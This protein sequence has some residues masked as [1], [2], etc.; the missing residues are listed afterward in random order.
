MSINERP[1]ILDEKTRIGD[2]EIDTVIGKNH[3]LAIV[4]IV[5]RKSK[6][7]LL[8]K[9]SHKQLLRLHKQL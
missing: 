5:E 6:V 4:S 1:S 3:K 9:V 8:A 7:T 2:W